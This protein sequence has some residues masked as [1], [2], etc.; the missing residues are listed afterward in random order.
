MIKNKTVMQLDQ[1]K[2]SAI[3]KKY[4]IKFPKTLLF[5]KAADF[6]PGKLK[7]PAALKVDSSEIIHKTE[8]KL[9]YTNL[10]D[11][12]QVRESIIDA[13]KKLKSLKIK[14]YSF[15]LQEMVTGIEFILGMKT[16][17]TF[18]KIIVFGPGGIFVDLFRDTVM[19]VAPLSKKE[20]VDMIDS[21]K[22]RKLLEGFRNMPAVNKDKLAGLI[23]SFSKLAVKEKQLSEIDFNPVIAN[24]YDAIVVD[25]RMI[26]N[27]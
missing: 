19:R 16:D 3:L 6:D 27:A 20:A 21:I 15:I 22:S 8:Y 25:A 7:F 1:T 14:N 4:S 18:G 12:R 13:E 24:E 5:K 17:K 23:L 9:V 10:G 26:E 11:A 2:A